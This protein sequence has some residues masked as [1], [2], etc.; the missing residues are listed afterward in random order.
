MVGWLV[1]DDW[2]FDDWLDVDWLFDD[3]LNVHWL[4][5]DDWLFNDVLVDRLLRL[6]VVGL[7]A[8]VVVLRF[9][10]VVGFF[11]HWSGVWLFNLFVRLGED[12]LVAWLV[13]AVSVAVEG[14]HESLGLV[15]LGLEEGI[16]DGA[17][18]V[19]E[20]VEFV[21][22]ALGEGVSGNFLGGGEVFS[23]TDEEG[24]EPFKSGASFGSESG[25]DGLD[26]PW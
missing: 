25:P 20:A 24:V 9:L 5:D 10:G 1:D 8:L 4:F 7:L 18:G 23:L 22:E 2:F 6:V 12:W 15:V 21:G 17:E 26:S 11:V 3:W 14:V 19:S 13:V 16:S